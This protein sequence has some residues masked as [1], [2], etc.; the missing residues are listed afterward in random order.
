MLSAQAL[1][2]PMNVIFTQIL[3]SREQSMP[4]LH[5]SRD[6]GRAIP[7]ANFNVNHYIGWKGWEKEVE[8]CGDLM[9]VE[10]RA[11]LVFTCLSSIIIS[12]ILHREAYTINSLNK[13]SL[14]KKR[15]SVF[16]WRTAT[17]R[18]ALQLTNTVSERQQISTLS[19]NES[20]VCLQTEVV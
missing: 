13:S 16:L 1:L 2:P 18:T 11:I 6:A 14:G 15:H 7:C 9:L 12:L 3:M 5:D 8:F 20:Y 17:S 19:V 4:A 10:F